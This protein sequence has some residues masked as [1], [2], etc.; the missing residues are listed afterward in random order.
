MV[1]RAPGFW[2]IADT[3]TQR[4]RRVPREHP[5]AGFVPHVG[6]PPTPRSPP[7]LEAAQR[8]VTPHR[9][10]LR[11]A[12]LV[13]PLTRARAPAHSAH[14]RNGAALAA[15]SAVALTRAPPTEAGECLLV[16]AAELGGRWHADCHEL[17]RLLVA[18]AAA[19]WRPRTR[20][21]VAGSSCLDPTERAEPNA[22]AHSRL[23]WH[24]RLVVR[25]KKKCEPSFSPF[26]GF[27]ALRCCTFRGTRHYNGE[28]HRDFMMARSY[29]A[30]R[31]FAQR[32]GWHKLH[33]VTW[34]YMLYWLHTHSIKI[35][36]WCFSAVLWGSLI[37]AH[38]S[39]DGEQ[40]GG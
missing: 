30:L 6:P 8:G 15:V 20:R 13:S 12:T 1:Y 22:N 33:M 26:C 24:P 36:A 29:S 2:T 28:N 5:R 4:C 32:S 3:P 23:H 19:G 10:M 38:H 40:V 34:S 16:L 35:F 31:W 11:Y 17:I 21:R 25:R 27:E 7:G 14:A 39:S 37:C 9:E 18:A